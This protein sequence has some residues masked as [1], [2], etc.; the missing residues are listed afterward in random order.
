MN[1]GQNSS[2]QEYDRFTSQSAAASWDRQTKATLSG[3]SAK[4]ADTI[5]TPRHPDY[6]IDLPWCEVDELPPLDLIPVEV[7]RRPSHRVKRKGLK[8]ESPV[9]GLGL[10]GV[11]DHNRLEPLPGD[12]LAKLTSTMAAV[13]IEPKS[14]V[15][16]ASGPG[17][18]HAAKQR[19]GQRRASRL[20]PYSP[21]QSPRPLPMPL[22]QNL[23][24]VEGHQSAAGEGTDAALLSPLMLPT[25]WA[26][27][28]EP[29]RRSSAQSAAH[30][31]T[32]SIPRS[33]YSSASPAR[34]VLARPPLMLPEEPYCPPAWPVPG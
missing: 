22:L 18:K 34:S 13:A 2:F 19:R 29:S 15:D 26:P 8:R 30:S 6:T 3:E 7:T 28:V 5:D 17:K 24:P 21:E 33:R 9:I 25:T 32:A 12:S 11:E 14:Q 10:L 27:S 23:P 20:H 4:Y 16:W 1:I 31:R